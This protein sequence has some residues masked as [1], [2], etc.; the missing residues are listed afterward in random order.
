MRF[1]PEL[2]WSCRRLWSAAPTSRKNV[3]QSPLDSMYRCADCLLCLNIEV[4]AIVEGEYTER[5]ANMVVH[6]SDR[7]I[8]LCPLSPRLPETDQ[9]VRATGHRADNHLGEHKGSEMFWSSARNNAVRHDAYCRQVNDNRQGTKNLRNGCV[10]I[11]V[12]SGSQP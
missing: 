5:I 10:G 8:A 4:L 1:H 7:L 9:Q 6:I 11:H 3:F 12:C 2:L